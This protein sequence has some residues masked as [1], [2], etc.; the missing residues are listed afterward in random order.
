MQN[1]PGIVQMP[2]SGLQQTSPAPHVVFPQRTPAAA[3]LPACA[4]DV[5]PTFAK[6]PLL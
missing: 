4:T 1:W 6:Q 3:Q 5:P 2:R